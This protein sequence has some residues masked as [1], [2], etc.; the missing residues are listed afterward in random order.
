MDADE[1]LARANQ[2]SS[3]LV[4]MQQS[5]SEGAIYAVEGI[6]MPTARDEIGPQRPRY[7]L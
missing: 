2:C 3:A 4:R 5:T 7:S 6:G 1:L